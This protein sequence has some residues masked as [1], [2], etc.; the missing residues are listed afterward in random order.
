MV[1]HKLRF[2]HPRAFRCRDYTARLIE[3]RILSSE[4]G[5]RLRTNLLGLGQMS[6][7]TMIQGP[8][9]RARPTAQFRESNGVRKTHFS[10]V[11]TRRE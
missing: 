5:L 2:Q 8:P 3:T 10:R 7:R 11:E 9:Q 4:L 1:L 6:A